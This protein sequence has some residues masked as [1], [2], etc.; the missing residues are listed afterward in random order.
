MPKLNNLKILSLSMMIFLA[1]S[2]QSAEEYT[3]KIVSLNVETFMFGT[4]AAL[5]GYIQYA[6]RL[7]EIIKPSITNQKGNAIAQG[8][9]LAKMDPNPWAA[10]LKQYIVGG[11]V[12]KEEMYLALRNH[13]RYK[14]LTEKNAVSLESLTNMDYTLYQ[15]KGQYKDMLDEAL[16][17]KEVLESCIAISPFEGLVTKLYFAQGQA[18]GRPPIADIVQ[19]NPI[20]LQIEL[21]QEKLN[22][23]AITTP[24]KFYH[25]NSDVSYD[26]LKSFSMFKGDKLL[27]SADNYHILNKNEIIADINIPIVREWSPVLKF[28]L[29]SDFHGL[30][31]VANYAIEKDADGYFVWRAK[32]QKIMQTSKGIEPIFKIEKIYFKPLE[33]TRYRTPYE[34]ITAVSDSDKLELYDIVI[35][36]PPKDLKEGQNVCCPQ[37]RYLF[38]PG[39]EVRVV[40]GSG[41]IT[42]SKPKDEKK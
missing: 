12:S 35:K 38:M 18:T 39:D 5:M 30:L 8:T 20:G 21:P 17:N 2:I 25:L 42:N 23:I 22:E 7:G 16:M 28:G 4:D 14:F 33:L 36:K 34:T 1:L 41:P 11:K 40:I 3:G 26:V 29:D 32:G 15:D 9:M 24:I 19:L 13:L 6:P 37:R 31:G 27:L 10:A